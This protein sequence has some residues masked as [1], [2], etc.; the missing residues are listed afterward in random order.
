MRYVVGLSA[1]RPHFLDANMQAGRDVRISVTLQN[2]LFDRR[3]LFKFT[4]LLSTSLEGVLYLCLKPRLP[5]LRGRRE[6][7]APVVVPST[8]VS[9]YSPPRPSGTVEDALN[10]TTTDA[11]QW[12]TPIPPLSVEPVPTPPPRPTH[13]LIIDQYDA[14]P[15]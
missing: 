14:R 11:H 1:A 2:L 6:V 15:L 5:I 3:Q 4:A 8:Y 12:P 9:N 13:L 10:D 7:A